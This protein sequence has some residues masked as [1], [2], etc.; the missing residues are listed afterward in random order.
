MNSE[1]TLLATASEKV[2]YQ[3]MWSR[4]NVSQPYFIGNRS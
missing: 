2:K 4:E 1:G 3:W